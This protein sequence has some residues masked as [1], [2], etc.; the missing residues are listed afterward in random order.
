M[1]LEYTRNKKVNNL[2]VWTWLY[3]PENI[4]GVGVCFGASYGLAFEKTFEGV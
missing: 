4:G 1:I 3:P 2:P